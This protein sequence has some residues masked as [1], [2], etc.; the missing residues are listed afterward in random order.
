MLDLDAAVQLE[1]EEVAALEHELGRTG[2]DVAD[3]GRESHR[4]VA[5]PCAQLGIERRRRRLLEHLLVAALHRALPLAEREHGAVGIGEQLDLDVARALE[6]A[7]QVDAVVAET[8]LRL[9]SCRLERG[10]EL[11]GGA[12]DAHPSSAAAGRRLDDQRRRLGLGDRRD[13]CLGGD[14]LRLQLVATAAKRVGWRP[15]P[16]QPG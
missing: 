7:L 11:L 8:R 12:D 1:E 15:D 6:V 5:H 2:P 4:R 16:R 13:A 3:R 9:S 10:R 14:A